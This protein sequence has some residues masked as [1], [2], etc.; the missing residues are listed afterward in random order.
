M[1]RFVQKFNFCFFQFSILSNLSKPGNIALFFIYK[2]L[3]Q[4][5][6][7]FMKNVD[8]VILDASE[9]TLKKLQELDM[10]TQLSSITFYDAYAAAHDL[11]KNESPHSRT[12]VFHK[13]KRL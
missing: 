2:Q 12:K 7:K 9:K 13:S 11:H 8:D 3:S 1:L 4:V 6:R 10:K 5:E